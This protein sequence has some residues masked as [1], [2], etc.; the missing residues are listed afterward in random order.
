MELSFGEQIKILLNRKHM[1]IKDLA[2]LYTQSTGQ[3]MSR[4]NLTQRLKRDNFPEQDMYT[5]AGLLGY[6]VSIRLEPAD[7]IA[8]EYAWPQ[9]A[10]ELPPHM[11]QPSSLPDMKN[12]TD[13]AVPQMSQTPSPTLSEK[14]TDQD[15]SSGTDDM[16]DRTLE[17]GDRIT[18]QIPEAFRRVRPAGEINPLTGEEYLNNTVRQHP[19]L[20]GFLQVYDRATHSWSD[21]EENY[22][23]EFQEKK[24]QMLV[25][26]AFRGIQVCVVYLI[27]SAGWKMV[28]KL[29][30]RPLDNAILAIVLLAM[31]A[32][33]ML[34]VSFSSIY[35]IL[36]SGTAG[37]CV[38]GVRQLRRGGGKP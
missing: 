11:A 1:T 4:Q 33:S 16:I 7:R 14:N 21:V 31:L 17:N 20:E 19:E 38:Y 6:R 30:H 25:G 28:R 35:F 8:S 24:K 22:F 36:L 2:D 5:I 15:S 13:I 29:P 18:F 27:A 32:C 34:A 12:E 37:L 26:Y 9:A 3:P 23:W 10:R